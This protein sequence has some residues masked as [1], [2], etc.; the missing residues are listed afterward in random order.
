MSKGGPWR[1]WRVWTGSYKR[2]GW[3]H[4]VYPAWKRGDWGETP[5]RS[6]VSLRGEENGQTLFSFL[7]CPVTEL[8]VNGMKLCQ[9][10]FRLD[11]RKTFFTQTMGGHWKRLLREVLT[12]PSLTQ[13]RKCLDN[14]LRP[15]VWIFGVVLNRTRR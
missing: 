4:L 10:S 11:I 15:V 13:F 3:S 7:W 1:S 2:S 14:S 8:K 6:T 9:G 5:E 12:A